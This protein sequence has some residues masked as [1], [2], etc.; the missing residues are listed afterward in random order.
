MKRTRTLRFFEKAFYDTNSR[1]FA[2][3]NDFFAFTTIVS[4][5]V[6]VLETVPSL[7]PYY[8]LLHGIEWATVLLFTFEY[9][10]RLLTANNK[11]G[12]AF[13]F[14]GLLDLL[15]ILPSFL[16]LANLTFLKTARTL[17]IL[18]FLRI[19]RLAKLAR[20]ETMHGNHKEESMGD[21]IR[22]N[23]GIYATAII[24]SVLVLGTLI[25]I[26]EGHYT[27]AFESIP[28]GMVWTLQILIGAP[29]PSAQ[30]AGGI[31]VFVG[32]KMLAL[33]LFGAF[34]GLIGTLV[35]GA[36]LGKGAK[37]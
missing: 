23:L 5:T 12:Y 13:S 15:S 19:L 3:T 1:I 4:L 25:Y 30:T 33:L 24:G 29:F 34:T 35:Q 10:G 20:A 2:W 16:G 31:W 27:P 14:F 36:L 32:V 37:K 18:R 9:L 26:V 17:R 22:L 11:P 6:L 28:L 7:H 21:V 8:P